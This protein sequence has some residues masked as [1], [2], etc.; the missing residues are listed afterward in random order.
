MKKTDGRQRHLSTHKGSIDW[1]AAKERFVLFN[2]QA[3]DGSKYSL[4]QLSIDLKLNYATLR[5]K[6]SVCKWEEFL[7]NQ[8]IIRD[9]SVRTKLI[10][11][12]KM[13]LDLLAKDLANRETEIRKKHAILARMMQKA[14]VDKLSNVKSE[15]LKVRDAIEL[16]KLGISEERKALGLADR[17]EFIGLPKEVNENIFPVSKATELLNNIITLVEKEE[18]LFEEGSE[19]ESSESNKEDD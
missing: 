7:N 11:R 6:A 8:I 15:D 1:G 12:N 16:L 3:R 5:N 18:G 4:K 14:A 17:F 2:L 19:T 9:D 13:S 10:E